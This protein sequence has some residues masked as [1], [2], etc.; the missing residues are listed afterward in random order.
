MTPT[1]VP[2]G[3]NE[4]ALLN[5]L[6][7]VSKTFFSATSPVAERGVC[8][9]G[10][11]P[12]SRLCCDSSCLGTTFRPGPGGPVGTGEIMTGSLTLRLSSLL[13]KALYNLLRLCL[14][15]SWLSS[16]AEETGAASRPKPGDCP[17]P[18]LPPLLPTPL[19]HS[20]LAKRRLQISVCFHTIP[21]RDRSK[22]QGL[23][24]VYGC[25]A[26]QAFKK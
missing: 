14:Q 7:H 5:M 9:Q 4:K 15:P 23:Y 1:L 6:K 3:M 22:T 10:L 12:R 11:P 19:G 20:S 24:S 16:L 25:F 8:R 18:F 13:L 26:C 21:G 17:L 2:S